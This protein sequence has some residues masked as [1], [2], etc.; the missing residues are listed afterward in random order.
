MPLWKRGMSKLG[1]YHAVGADFRIAGLLYRATGG[2]ITVCNSRSSVMKRRLAI[3]AIVGF[4]VAGV[5]ALYA[6]ASTP[7]ALGPAAPLITL[8]RLTCPTALLSFYPLSVYSV[9]FANAATY[10]LV[11]WMVETLRGRFRHAE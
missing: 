11:G 3:W 2:I 5:W 9:L 6:L 1:H 4:L 7:P 8:V 10:A